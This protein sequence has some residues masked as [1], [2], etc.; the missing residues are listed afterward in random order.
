MWSMATRRIA[1]IG[2]YVAALAVV[3]MLLPFFGCDRKA[4]PKRRV[5]ILGLDGATFD[6]IEPWAAEGHLP[7]LRS[8]MDS[9]AYGVLN[10]VMPPMSPPA[11]TTAITGVNPGEHAIFDFVYRLP[12]GGTLLSQTARGRRAMPIWAILSDRGRKVGVVNIPVTDPPDVVN[13]FMISG[14]PHPER[15]GYTYPPELEGELE[16]YRIDSMGDALEPG[17]GEMDLLQNFIEVRDQRLKAILKLMSE[18]EWDFFWAVFT[19]CDRVQ[20][21]FWKFMDENHPGYDP[22]AAPELKNAIF[23]FWVGL[24]K[25]VG[26]IM[27]AM[28]EDVTVIVMSDHGFGPIYKELRL[29]NLLR[30]RDLEGPDICYA[31]GYEGQQIF[32][33]L[34][35]KLPGGVVPPDQYEQTRDK[36]AR[37]LLEATDPETGET[38]VEAVYRKEEVFS[39]LY[40]TKAP[41]LVALERPFYFI[42]SDTLAGRDPVGPV[43]SSFNAWHRPEGIVMVI[44]EGVSTGRV[45]NPQSIMDIAPTALYLMG[46]P[47]PRSIEGRVMEDVFE[48]AYFAAGPIRYSDESTRFEGEEREYTEEELERL[49]AVPYLR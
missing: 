1:S 18:R 40:S 37:A 8:L 23:N 45:P 32:V 20:H 47:I 46:E 22:D 36:I 26:R 14:L 25:G 4:G 19:T 6:L 15:R 29:H 12:D 35:G 13:G 44:G 9:S 17:A 38:M 7:N 31:N 48:P 42:Q 39:G 30:G 49:K 11:W 34:K 43:T 21:F 24:D 3:L 33:N 28:P 5:F 10:S 41:D 2:K 16:G 27:D